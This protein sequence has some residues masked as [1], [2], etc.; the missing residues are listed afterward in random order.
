MHACNY[1]HFIRRGSPVFHFV[2]FTK[3]RLPLRRVRMINDAMFVLRTGMTVPCHS[4]MLAMSH[5]CLLAVVVCWLRKLKIAPSSFPLDFQLTPEC[6]HI[7][8]FWTNYKDNAK[9]DRLILES[10]L[11][12]LAV[13]PERGALLDVPKDFEDFW[14]IRFR[15]LQVSWRLACWRFAPRCGLPY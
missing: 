5:I 12:V 10:F 6:W 2:E 4:M 7:I 1:T 13:I 14:S 11:S 3:G 15:Q 9:L 8:G